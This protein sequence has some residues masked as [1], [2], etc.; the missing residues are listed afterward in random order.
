MPDVDPSDLESILARLNA[1]EAKLA[2]TEAELLATKAELARK[3][4]II[5]AL[6]QRLFG[7]SSERLDPAQLQL[8]F[9][10]IVLG[11]AAAP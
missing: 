11:K 2:A 5:A 3:N 8:E 10:E 9:D 1:V 7:S 4:E 6:Q